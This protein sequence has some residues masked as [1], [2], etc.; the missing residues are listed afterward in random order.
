MNTQGEQQVNKSPPGATWVSRARYADMRGW[1]R[2]YV[3]KLGQQNRLVLSEDGRH[4]NVEAT[5]RLLTQSA[6]P[7]KAHVAQRHQIGRVDRAVGQHIRPDAPIFGDPP[8]AARAADP[9]GDGYW[10]AKGRR[11]KSLAQMAELELQERMKALVRRDQVVTATQA[12][13]RMLRDSLLGMPTRLAPE[14]AAMTDAF[15]VERLMREAISGILSDLSKMT[16]QDLQAL[17][18]NRSSH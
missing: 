11:E 2:S 14:L 5:D 15:E 18:G 1:N 12:V 16:A 17:E 10:S 3:T 6:D 7:G 8:P 4:V 13:H 9:D